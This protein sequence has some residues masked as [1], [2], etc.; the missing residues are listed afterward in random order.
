[1]VFLFGAGSRGEMFAQVVDFVTML[2]DTYVTLLAKSDALT[3]IIA[4][5]AEISHLTHEWCFLIAL[6]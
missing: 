2:H 3:H 6:R 5:A 4:K 1:M